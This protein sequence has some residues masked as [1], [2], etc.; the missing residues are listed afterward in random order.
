[1]ALINL[2]MIDKNL[3]PMP[4]ACVFCFL[5][6]IINKYFRDIVSNNMVINFTT[7]FSRFLAVIPFIILKKNT[8]KDHNIETIKNNTVIEYIFTGNKEENVKGKWTY[9]ILSSLIYFI[10][11]VLFGIT[12][13]IPTNTWNLYILI[14]PIFYYLIFKIKL[15]KHHYLSIILILLV[16]AVID[17][18]LGNYQ[19]EMV[20]N[21]YWLL[22]KLI[23]EIIFSLHNVL[24][25]Y[26]MEKKFVSVYEYSFYNGVICIILSVTYSILDYFYFKQNN[27]EDFFNNINTNKILVLLGQLITQFF[28]NLTLLLTIRNTSPCHA[29]IIYVFGQFAYYLEISLKSIIVFNCLIIILFLS[30]IFNEIIEINFLGLSHNTRKNII[31]RAGRENEFFKLFFLLVNI[32]L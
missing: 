2:G 30:L 31:F 8:K 23:R 25:K 7:S 5:N 12:A 9:I 28:L 21:Y 32:F 6:R 4:I 20:N 1:M 16:G 13:K 24:A 18:S 3:I 29:F 27:Y 15:Y 19:K 26:L 10:Q 22:L 17:F 14:T 11:S